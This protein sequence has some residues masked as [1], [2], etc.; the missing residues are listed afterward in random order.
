MKLLIFND[1]PFFWIFQDFLEIKKEENSVRDPRGANMAA[2]PSGNVPACQ[3][4]A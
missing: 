3:L 2:M 4:E 1:L